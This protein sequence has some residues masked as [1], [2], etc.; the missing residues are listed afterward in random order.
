MKKQ[1]SGS[2]IREAGIA[3]LLFLLFSVFSPFPA[4]RSP[5]P[6]AFADEIKIRTIVTPIGSQSEKWGAAGLMVCIGGKPINQG[7]CGVDDVKAYDL[8]GNEITIKQDT[9]H[10]P[11]Q[12]G[13]DED[14]GKLIIFKDKIDPATGKGDHQFTKTIHSSK[15]DTVYEVRG[16]GG[17]GNCAAVTA[18]N[19]GPVGGSI[20]STAT[21][22]AG[23]TIRSACTVGADCCGQW[24]SS[25]SIAMWNCLDSPTHSCV[26]GTSCS[27]SYSASVWSVKP[28]TYVRILCCE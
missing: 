21:C 12:A 20:T 10:F 16:S 3:L 18:H 8:N 9:C 25:Q 19:I 2:G 24:Y 13:D 6:A 27:T 4:T 28:L 17:G 14:C 23:M 15:Y 11:V 26:G 22:P 1:F 7:G 5:L